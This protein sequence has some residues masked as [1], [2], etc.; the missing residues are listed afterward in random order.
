MRPKSLAEVARLTLAGD[1]FNRCLA[2]FLD[3]LYSSPSAMALSEAPPLLQPS[4][5]DIGRVRDAYL[6]APPRR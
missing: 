4:G 3:E 1:S 5:G 6:G 2:D